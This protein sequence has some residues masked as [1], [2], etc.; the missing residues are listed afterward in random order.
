VYGAT[1]PADQNPVTG[2][3]FTAVSTEISG[4][5]GN[6]TYHYRVVAE[7]NTG[8][9]YG[10]DI[11]FFTGASLPVAITDTATYIGTTTARLNG[12][13][14]ANNATASI[15]FEYGLDTIYGR[16]VEAEPN[17]VSGSENTAVY[18]TL[19]NLLPGTI[20]HYRVVAVNSVGT[21]NGTDE[22][23]TT[24]L[25]DGIDSEQVKF[26]VP[27]AYSLSQNY[28]NPFNPSTVIEFTLPKAGY[29]ELRIYN[30]LGLE[31][32]TLVSKKLNQGYYFYQFDGKDLPSGVYYYRLATG[33]FQDVKK[34]I[35]LR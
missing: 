35:L 32:V 4:L 22:T 7:N 27:T 11:T 18:A 13:V 25:V 33:E 8:T 19:T 34:M 20:Y 9:A 17:L 31:M 23:F 29:V 24:S 26:S 5:T 16:S 6:T 28:P 10:A 21:A 14:I 3:S 30:L 15:S 12:T 2:N 1:V